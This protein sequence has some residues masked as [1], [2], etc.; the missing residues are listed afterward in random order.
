MKEFFK[1][2][3]KRILKILIIVVDALCIPGAI[4]CQNLSGNM[5]QADAPCVW[6]TIGIECFTCGGTH[7][8]ND[9]LSFRII[10]AMVDNPLLFVLSVYLLIT[11]IAMNLYWLFKIKFA[12]RMLRLMYNVPVIIAWVVAGCIFF[13]IRNFDAFMHLDVVL[14]K[15]IKV[16]LWMVGITT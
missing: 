12:R 11:L 6:T 7:F 10:D 1:K 5:L 14:P 15:V 13:F 2:Y 8:V 9:L 16:C 4:I 3:Y